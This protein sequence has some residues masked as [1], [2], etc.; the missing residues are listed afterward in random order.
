ML[1]NRRTNQDLVSAVLLDARAF[2]IRQREEG[3]LRALLFESNP[4]VFEVCAGRADPD[5]E[6]RGRADELCRFG[7][8]YG[9]AGHA[10]G[11]NEDAAGGE[12]EHDEEA[13]EEAHRM[14]IP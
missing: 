7:D 3:V 10:S 1:A 9:W 4:Q 5:L 13:E 11:G 14:M 2:L 12:R 8:V 6:R